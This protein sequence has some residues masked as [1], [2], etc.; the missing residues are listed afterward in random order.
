MLRIP[1]ESTVASARRAAL[2]L[3]AGVLAIQG[4]PGSGKTFAG[5]RMIIDLVRAKKKVGVTA[6]SHKVIRN[7][8]NELV[9][10]AAEEQ[11]HIR[12]MHRLTEKFR[13]PIAGIDE[14]CDSGKAVARILNREY[15][16]VGGTAWVWSKENL[17]CTIDVLVVDEAG[18]MSLA[19]VLACSQ[20]AKSL[21]LLGDPQQLE[22]PQKACHPEGSELSALEYLLEGHET[23]PPQRGLFLGETWRLHPAICRFT[24]E[25][26]YEGKLTSEASLAAQSLNG[27]TPFAGA[28][29]FQ[30]PVIH[31][32]NQNNSPEEASRIAEIVRDI[33]A[34]GVSW[35]NRHGESK[36]ITLETFS[37]SLP[38]TRRF[39]KS[40]SAFQGRALVR[41]TSSR[42]RKRRSSSTRPLP[43]VRRTRRTAWSSC[44]AATGSTL[45]PHEPAASVSSLAIRRSSSR[46]AGRR[47]RCGWR[48]RIAGISRWRQPC[49]M[50]GLVLRCAG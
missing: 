41:S 32:G 30:V 34:P 45:P 50:Q 19:N 33:V 6:V 3:D 44:L 12:C 35:T 43:R 29:L 26:F 7:L 24:S 28:G 5:A 1:N 4:P 15:D 2:K 38:T 20:A 8:L 11:T 23:L 36:P 49:D 47:S 27:P 14:E 18:Q 46:T 17:A 21:V 42:A 22:Q 25:L 10:A 31:E 9:R 13:T 48:M 16:V 40:P 39:P 37:S